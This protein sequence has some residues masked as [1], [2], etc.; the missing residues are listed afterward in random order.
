M[1]K[2]LQ[3]STVINKCKKILSQFGTAKELLTDNGP[4]STSHHFKTF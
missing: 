1:L 4:K 3:S 2:Y